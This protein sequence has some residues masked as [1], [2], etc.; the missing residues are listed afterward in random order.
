M[1]PSTEAAEK[2][3][4]QKVL[5]QGASLLAPKPQ[6]NQRGLQALRVALLEI[7]PLIPIFQQAV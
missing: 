4:R 1:D 6:Q 3:T 5:Y 2:P 7:H